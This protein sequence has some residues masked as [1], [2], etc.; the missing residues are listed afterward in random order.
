MSLTFIVTGEALDLKNSRSFIISITRLKAFDEHIDKRLAVCYLVI[1][2]VGNKSSHH[3]HS[4]S[5]PRH[6][7]IPKHLRPE[8]RVCA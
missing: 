1:N 3:G 6:F 5:V 2:D 4:I 7:R 8:L